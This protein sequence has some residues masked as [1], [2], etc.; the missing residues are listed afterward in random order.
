MPDNTSIKTLNVFFA[1][2]RN[3]QQ[4]HIQYKISMIG[5]PEWQTYTGTLLKDFYTYDTYIYSSYYRNP[6]QERTSTF[7]RNF[8]NN[9]K[10]PMIISYPRYGMMGFDMGYYFLRGLSR[11][12]DFFEQCQGEMQLQPVQHPFRFVGGSG[13]EGYT[14]RDNSNYAG[15]IQGG[16]NSYSFLTIGN[17]T[18]QDEDGDG[19][20]NR[21]ETINIIYE[22][23]NTSRNAV[24]DVELKIEALDGDKYFA[25]SP[26]NSVKIAAGECIRYKAK[27]FCKSK[28]SKSPAQF[29]LSAS[30]RYAGS[31]STILQI[32]INK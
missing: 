2:L 8:M 1:K 6:L 15:Q 19:R 21:N 11:Y 10:R 18:Y 25:V 4:N 12:G 32:K 29:K 23:T 31:T 26:S 22:V 16:S 3:F 30:S 9:F 13:D 7:E 28:P 27:A 20:I 5:Y 17:V 14:N 24:D